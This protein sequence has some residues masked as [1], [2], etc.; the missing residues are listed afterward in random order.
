LKI[1]N[2]SG[3]SEGEKLMPIKSIKNWN[4]LANSE[5]K[6]DCLVWLFIQ[7]ALEG[8]HEAWREEMQELPV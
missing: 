8:A 4:Y 1:V 7:K 2:F 6:D 5:K 3:F